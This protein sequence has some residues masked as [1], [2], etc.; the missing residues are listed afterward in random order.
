[1]LATT[2]YQQVSAGGAG[3]RPGPR[4]ARPRAGG[5]ARSGAGPISAAERVG[6]H[7]D[8][9]D[10][11]AEPEARPHRAAAGRCSRASTPRRCRTS[12]MRAERAGAHRDRVLLGQPPRDLARLDARHVERRERDARDVVAAPLLEQRAGP[13]RRRAAR[14]GARRASAPRPRA[15]ACRRPRARRR[16]RR[17]RSRRRRSACRPRSARAHRTRRRGRRARARRRRRRAAAARRSRSAARAR[18]HADA[19]RRVELVAREREV[20]DPERF[21]V[22]RHVR[23]ELGRVDADLGAVAVRQLGELARPAGSRPSRWTRPRS[24]SRS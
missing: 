15:A 21:H 23:R 19:E 1:M 24:R 9:V 18:Q 13:G 3:P 16:R 20:V 2:A 17:A 4:S 14:A 7:L 5:R 6:Q 11:G 12:G 22:D 8:V 10:A